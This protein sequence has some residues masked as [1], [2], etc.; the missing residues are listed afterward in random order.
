[1]EE[2]LAEIWQQLLRV[3]RVGREDN[4]F[5]LGGHSLHVMKLKLKVAERLMV[6][7]SVPAV[8]QYPTIQQMATVIE[9]LRVVN[10]EPP[11]SE[12]AV[13]EEGVI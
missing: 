2:I 1:V 3:E 8:F 5:E 10:G 4:F 7:L 12:G 6:G 9:S 13:F 11:E